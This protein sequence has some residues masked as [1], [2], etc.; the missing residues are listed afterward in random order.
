MKLEHKALIST[1]SLAALLPSCVA[2]EKPA[3]SAPPVAV[4][5]ATSGVTAAAAT[6]ETA[7][8]VAVA[9]GTPPGT[10]TTEPAQPP[11][12]PQAA[13]TKSLTSTPAATRTP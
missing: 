9:P 3:D 12:L 8:P 10:A 11:Q 2:S 7:I 4:A 1:L 5:P 6:P 13:P